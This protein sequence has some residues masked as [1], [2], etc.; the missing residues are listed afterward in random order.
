VIQLL[1]RADDAAL[2]AALALRKGLVATT[3]AALIDILGFWSSGR[4]L[5]SKR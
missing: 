5:I 2:V 3:A 4:V 1:G